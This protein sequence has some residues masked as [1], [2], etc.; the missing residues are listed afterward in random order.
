ML[1]IY[2][3][4]VNIIVSEK[5]TVH[6]KASNII[7][8]LMDMENDSRIRVRFKTNVEEIRVTDVAIAVP[9]KLVNIFI[10]YHYLISPQN[11]YL[12]FICTRVDP[13]YL[14]SSITS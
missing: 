2:Q 11:K 9:I 7:I 6:F 13:A 1:T 5:A 4:K 10:F 12:I 14:K 3:F 8:D